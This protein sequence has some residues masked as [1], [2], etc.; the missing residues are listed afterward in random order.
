[1]IKKMKKLWISTI[2]LKIWKTN[3]H[4]RLKKNKLMFKKSLSFE[5]SNKILN[6]FA[7][8]ILTSQKKQ[9]TYEKIFMKNKLNRLKQ[10]LKYENKL[11]KKLFHVIKEIAISL[12]DLIFYMNFFWNHKRSSNYR[13]KKS[14]QSRNNYNV[15]KSCK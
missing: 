1:M 13:W 3:H 12:V 2:S 9:R 8:S 15:A 5:K 11:I 4:S 6:V 14:H 10:Q 7:S